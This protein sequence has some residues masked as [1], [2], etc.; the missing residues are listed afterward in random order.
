MTTALRLNDIPPARYGPEATP[1]TCDEEDRRNT[2]PVRLLIPPNEDVEQALVSSASD[3]E[4]TKHEAEV[5]VKED[6]KADILG[7]AN[8]A[9]TCDR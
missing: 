5:K 6:E 2:R 3:K 9:T 4:K 8:R 1:A 7:G